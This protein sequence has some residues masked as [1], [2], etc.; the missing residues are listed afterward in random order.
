[1]SIYFLRESRPPEPKA[2][3]ISRKM[4]AADQLPVF[5]AWRE[6]RKDFKFDDF[7][8]SRLLEVAEKFKLFDATV[9]PTKES[10]DCAW[11]IAK[12]LL[13]YKNEK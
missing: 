7:H 5:S 2:D 12:R 9:L 1:M 8:L 13:K 6:S 4:R 3:P 10:L 11:D